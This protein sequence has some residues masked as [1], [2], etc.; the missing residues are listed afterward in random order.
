MN[1]IVTIDANPK[2]TPLLLLV[3]MATL[4]ATSPAMAER[5]SQT[6]GGMFTQVGNEFRNILPD[7]V[8]AG[9]LLLSVF[10]VATGLARLVEMSNGG[11]DGLGKDA[12]MRLLGGGFLASVP[13]MLGSIS[14]TFFGQRLDGWGS[15]G[16]QAA[17]P[18]TCFVPTGGGIPFGCV[19]ENIAINVAKPGTLVLFGLAFV[20]GAYLVASGLYKLAVSQ[21]QGN[22]TEAKT[23]LPRVIFGALL[24][25]LPPLIG[26]IAFTLGYSSSIINVSGLQQVAAP[27][28]SIPGPTGMSSVELNSL[29][30]NIFMI[31]VL[32]GVLAVWRGIS[33]LR[34]F[35]EGQDREGIGMAM[36]HIVG[37]VMLTNVKMTICFVMGTFMGN[38]LGFC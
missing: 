27:S 29:L 6:V 13:L 23:W 4:F 2:K 8:L 31:C 35:S 1:P 7:L 17:S 36:T 26:T 14:S 38:G 5:A 33:K 34:S 32:F 19:A 28:L 11:R 9:S 30:G 12:T 21:G 24:A 15:A 18:N 25:Q 16:I 22:Q 37:G 20:A 3:L 10:L